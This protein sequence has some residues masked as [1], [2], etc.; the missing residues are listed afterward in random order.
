[1]T[2]ETRL[3]VRITHPDKVLF[4]RDGYTKSDVIEYYA[5]VANVMLPYLRDHPLAMLRFNQGIDGERFFHKNAPDYFPEFIGRAA[6]KTAKRT[7]MMPVVDNLEALL[8]IANHNC[9]EYHVLPV[10]TGDLWHPDRMVFDLDP[11]TEDFGLVK[12]AAGWLRDLLDELGLSAFV[13]TS[14][15]RGLH[16]WVPLDGAATVEDVGE[17]TNAVAH[18][19]TSRYPKELTTEFHKQE[20]GDRIYVDV[21]RNA[22]GQHA[23]APFS[24][25]AKDGAPVATPIAWE[26]LDDAG[27]TPTSFAL[28]DLPERA[29]AQSE[30]WKGMRRRAKSLGPAAKK[31]EKAGSG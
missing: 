7:T 22:P 29:E 11:S 4:P 3:P 2:E 5:S 25:R 28:R 26:A 19:L 15:S 1:M 6:M 18:V 13:M 23:V 9:I 17:F 21:G 31:L 14:G 30:T 12:Q 10:R 16:I 8:Y 24:L 27:L 20:R